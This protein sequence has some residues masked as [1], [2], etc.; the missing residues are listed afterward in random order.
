MDLTRRAARSR[1]GAALLG[2]ALLAGLAG[3]GCSSSDSPLEYSDDAVLLPATVREM[4]TVAYD[5][6]R[7]VSDRAY[8]TKMGGGFAI[9]N[10]EGRARHHSFIF[11][12]Q[13]GQAV[14]REITIHLIAGSSWITERSV[15]PPPPPFVDFD[16]LAD[17]DAA[18]ARALAVADSLN[19][20]APGSIP[21]PPGRGDPSAYEFAAKIS[22][23]PQWPEPG[24]G[25]PAD[26]RIAWRVDFLTEAVV[27][28]SGVLVPFSTVRFYFEPV[29]LDPLDD[30]IVSTELYPRP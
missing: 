23:V 12:A 11:H 18:V 19:A 2:T 10:S 24:S 16:E 30:P 4:Y 29:T 20:I 27:G 17:S 22:S 13:E 7:E 6:A 25:N 15:P 28:S 5:L 1:A 9:M 21:V 8:V 14:Y 3:A 26:P